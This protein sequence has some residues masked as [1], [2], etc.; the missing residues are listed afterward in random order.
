M[1]LTLF[2]CDVR[3]VGW[4]VVERVRVKERQEIN[5]VSQ[6]HCEASCKATSGFQGPFVTC[7]KKVHGCDSTLSLSSMSHILMLVI[8][9]DA[10]G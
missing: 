8:S 3:E 6:S 2:E 5:S 4:L 9:A 10:C 7:L 1:G